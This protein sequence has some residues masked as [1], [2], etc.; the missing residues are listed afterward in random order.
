MVSRSGGRRPG[1][2]LSMPP[3]RPSPPDERHRA[4]REEVARGQAYHHRRRQ[5]RAASG[6]GP[7]VLALAEAL[8][9]PVAT[10]LGARGI[11]PTRHRL[12]VGCAGKLCRA[13]GQP[14]RARGRTG[15]VHRLPHRRPGDAHL[16]HSG[17]RHAGGADRHRL[18]RTW[19]QLSEHARPDG[20]SESDAGQ[21]VRR[22]RQTRPRHRVRR[23]RRRYRRGL[24]GGAGAAP[25]QQCRADPARP[26]VRRNHQGA[27]G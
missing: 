19:P 12:S 10:S 26:A 7:E 18:L 15:A 4:R 3:H 24:A 17:D 23:P 25:R 22:H 27:A 9:A 8:A 16:A 13:A 14:D 20:R 11:I 2:Q 5:R 6:A 21:I 1:L